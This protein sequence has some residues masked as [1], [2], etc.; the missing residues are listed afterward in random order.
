MLKIMIFYT[1]KLVLFLSL[2]LGL[3][4]VLNTHYIGMYKEMERQEDNWQTA[5]RLYNLKEHPELVR[6]FYG[7]R[8]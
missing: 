8:K 3:C 1:L 2:L 7:W 6:Q 4:F 5:L